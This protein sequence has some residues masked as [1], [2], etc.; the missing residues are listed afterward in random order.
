MRQDWSFEDK[1]KNDLPIMIECVF[2]TT[3]ADKLQYFGQSL[4]AVLPVVG[5]V[6]SFSLLQLYDESLKV[7]LLPAHDRP[8]CAVPF[9][10]VDAQRSLSARDVE[11]VKR[12]SGSTQ[13]CR[14]HS[15]GTDLRSRCQSAIPQGLEGQA[16]E[17][18]ERGALTLEESDGLKRSRRDVEPCGT[19]FSVL[20]QELGGTPTGR[21]LSLLWQRLE[22][23]MPTDTPEYFEGLALEVRG[24]VKRSLELQGS[25]L[26]FATGGT[27][28]KKRR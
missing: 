7:V 13:G 20:F 19:E 28:A 22:V 11:R 17:E 15:N 18:H 21:V 16:L 10:C 6:P 26:C 27:P 23:G 2:N 14:I 9:H 1:A 3:R 5:F 24:S 12:S 25:Q 4:G 8:L